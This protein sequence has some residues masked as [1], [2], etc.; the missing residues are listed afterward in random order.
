MKHNFI[1]ICSFIIAMTIFL[2]YSIT[3]Y[4]LPKR[5]LDGTWIDMPLS[6]FGEEISYFIL[7]G[8]SQIGVFIHGGDFEQ[9]LKNNETYQ[10]LYDD[11]GRLAKNISIDTSTGN[12]TYTKEI[13]EVLKNA[14]DDYAK[15]NEPY[16][17][18]RTVP[19]TSIPYTAFNNQSNVYQSLKNLIADSSSGVVGV[20]FNWAT[21]AFTFTDIGSHFKDVGLV[22]HYYDGY[23]YKAEVKAY[24]I[25]TWKHANYPRYRLTLSDEDAVIKDKEDFI[26]R[27]TE[28]F[29]SYN[30]YL[31]FICLHDNVSIQSIERNV[32]VTGNQ[33]ANVLVSSDS[34]R[35]RVYNTYADFQDFTLGKRSIYYT[36]NYYDYVPEDLTVSID[37]LEKEIDDLS[38][39]IDQL[40]DQISK[41]T[42]ESE[43]EEL[44]RQ[45][46]EELRNSGGSG[47]GGGGSGG[48]VTVDID[49]STT[50]SWL[51]KI[52]AKVSQIF[53]K[54]SETVS[55]ASDTVHIKIQESLDEIIEQL[56]KIKRW[57]AI[58][59]VVDGVDAI[60]D[61]LDLIRGVLKDAKEGAGSA[62]S[63][64]ASGVGD[65]VDLMAKKFPFSIPWDI[66]FFVSALSA[67]PQ[68]PHFEIPFNIELS[69]LDITIDYTMELDFSQLQ[70]LSDLSRLLLSMT[71]AVGL[72]KLTFGV[73][74]VGKEE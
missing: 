48:D 39:V 59:T 64:I 61:W 29:T 23:G 72:M 14:A 60:A 35:I 46:L 2:S 3:S 4:A 41:D 22:K 38:K 15:E 66:L 13:M 49:L 16:T 57:T 63:A 43:I 34:R 62:V 8:L 68:V 21:G 58:D 50:N 10:D 54:L 9:W 44:L 31:R 65:S 30:E 56:K 55:G 73:T 37:D 27:A 42:D 33:V 53:D 51:S 69:A 32:I 24:E 6:E 67:E 19:L 25:S 18:Y 71:Y 26:A 20:S 1:R 17:M 12:V 36:S 40:L 47:G 70:W 45:I 11:N 28:T 7:Y 74:S 52:Y 5:L